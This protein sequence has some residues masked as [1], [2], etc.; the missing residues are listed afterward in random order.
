MANTSNPSLVPGRTPASTDGIRQQHSWDDF[1]EPIPRYVVHAY[2]VMVEEAL[3][4]LPGDR[5]VTHVF[6]QGGVGSIAAA[7]FLGFAKQH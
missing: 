4:Q 5:T 3:A 1:N 6:M 2:M 7:I